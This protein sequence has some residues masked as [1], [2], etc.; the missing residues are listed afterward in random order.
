MELYA[1]IPIFMR[2]FIAISD[3][4]VNSFSFNLRI[5]AFEKVPELELNSD[6]FN[7]IWRDE[8]NLDIMD[9]LLGLSNMIEYDRIE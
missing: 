4:Y 6:I 3:I 7:R 1:W 8:L 5:A 2:R 9:G